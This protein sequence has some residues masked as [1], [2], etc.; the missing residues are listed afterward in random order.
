MG[1]IFACCG[2]EVQ[3]EDAFRAY[4]WKEWDGIGYGTLCPKCVPVYHAVEADSFEDAEQKLKDAQPIGLIDILEGQYGGKR[5]V[6][7]IGGVNWG[8]YEMP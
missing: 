3:G 4:Y 7:N 6:R 2:H 1:E 5:E 8:I